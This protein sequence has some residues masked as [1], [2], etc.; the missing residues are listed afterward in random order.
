[1]QEWK[2]DNIQRVRLIAGIAM[3]ILGALILLV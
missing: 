1:M 2:R 3:I